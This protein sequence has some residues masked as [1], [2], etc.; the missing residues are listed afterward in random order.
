VLT[1]PQ[2][3][4]DVAHCLT[5]AIRDGDDYV[6]NGQ[7]SW[8]VTISPGLP[9]DSGVHQSRRKRHENLGWLYIPR[10]FPASPSSICI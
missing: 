4:S 5:K 6:V 9:L 1:E 3:G 10:I 2:G 7:K 8:S